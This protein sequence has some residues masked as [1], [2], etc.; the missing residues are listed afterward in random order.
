LQANL[1]NARLI[2]ISKACLQAAARVEPLPYDG[3]TR[4][5]VRLRGNDGGFA[6]SQMVPDKAGTLCKIYLTFT[7][8]DCNC[9]RDG[10]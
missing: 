3:F 6:D 7:K 1:I 10:V 4:D 5:V 2:R 8:K 9:R